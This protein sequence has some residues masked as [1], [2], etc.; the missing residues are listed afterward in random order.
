MANGTLAHDLRPE[1][2]PIPC[3]N[4]PEANIRLRDGTALTPADRATFETKAERGRAD[5][6]AAALPQ[7]AR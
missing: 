7:T 2:V 6:P 1:G 5:Y 3:L 4:R